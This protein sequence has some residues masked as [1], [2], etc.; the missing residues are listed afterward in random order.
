MYFTPTRRFALF[1]AAVC[2][3]ILSILSAP[4]TMA[5]NTYKNSFNSRY[6]TTGTRLDS[7]LT[8]HTTPTSPGP[9]NPYGDALFNRLNLGDAIGAALANIE[10]LDS[11][12]DTHSNLTEINARTFPG[13]PNDFP[14]A[15]SPNIAVAPTSLAF[16]SITVGGNSNLTVTVSNSGNAALTVS[17]LGLTGSADFSL[18]TPPSTPFNVA[19]G[20]SASVSVRYAPATAAADAGTLSIASN[21]P[22]TPLVS[23]SLSGTGV[24]CNT[25]VSPL[26][27]GFGE[28]ALGDSSTLIVTIANN[29]TSTCVVQNLT[30]TGSVDFDLGPTAPVTPFNL[31]PGS[32][33]MVPIVFAPSASGLRSA[34]LQV[35]SS[36]PDTPTTNVA[37]TGSG[38]PPPAV[39]QLTFTPLSVAFGNVAVGST[40]TASVTV[41]NKSTASCTVTSYNLTGSA[42]FAVG[43]GAPAT[44]FDVAP[45]T[46]IAI[47]LAYT[48]AT[49]AT[50]SGTLTVTGTD[51]INS[52]VNIPLSGTGVACHLGISPATLVY[53][54]ILVG[55]SSTQS[56]TLTNTGALACSVTSANVTGSADFALG[57]GSPAIPLTVQPGTSTPIPFAYTPTDAGADN[58][59]VTINSNDPDTPAQSVILT[60]AGQIPSPECDLLVT[61]A[62]VDFG[63][64][65]VAT[66]AT[67]LV[68]VQ[69]MGSASCTVTGLSVTGTGEFAL[70]NGAPATPFALAPAASVS[71]TL[72]YT[73]SNTGVDSGQLQIS[74]TDAS[75]PTITVSLAGTGIQSAL[76]ISPGTVDFGAVNVG[77]TASRVLT[78]HNDGTANCTV[79]SLAVTGSGEFSIGPSAP[80]TP[81]VVAPN[82]F[83]DVAVT[84]APTETGD[85]SG[86]IV[87]ESDDPANPMLTA[88]LAGTGQIRV[89]KVD[90]D[91][92]RFPVTGRYEIGSDDSPVQIRL[93]V[94]NNGR[95]DQEREAR[96]VGRQNGIVVYRETL[97]VT[98]PRGETK[99]FR[100]PPY[101]PTIKG[102]IEWSA[103]VQDDDPDQDTARTETTVAISADDDDPDDD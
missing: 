28:V 93:V 100:F 66:N 12:G 68:T 71:V 9:L 56:V 96:V 52:S 6:G 78:I 58:G 27:L 39:C 63:D 45:G 72:A 51:A 29:G 47:P 73:P 38:G 14:V 41:T 19:A 90:L 99:R 86:S 57:A 77:A 3:V 34:T 2:V 17:G 91:I 48:P 88:T 11:D 85:D 89:R 64:V 1:V 32:S 8:C 55:A 62:S 84:Y 98:A 97:M 101:T 81:F 10:P 70:G 82:S 76:G 74:S 15:T 13:N 30:L 103:I 18:V 42:D 7:C 22:D 60:G 95:A 54:T 67:A 5:F 49:A 50:D 53:G 44:P 46:G 65:P 25:T 61:P 31:T 59:L 75:D 92:I 37:L 79:L 26:T 80:M 16:G 102:R 24:A 94:R 83:V 36:D 43:A 69:N 21:D 33:V 20:G 35:A 4:D 87:V 23:V 40:G